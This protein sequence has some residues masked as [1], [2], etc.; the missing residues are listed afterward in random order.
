M[1][2]SIIRAKQRARDVLVAR[3]GAD[4]GVIDERR[5]VDGCLEIVGG[6]RQFTAGLDGVLKCAAVDRD[7]RAGLRGDG[8]HVPGDGAGNQLADD[9]AFGRYKGQAPIVVVEY[10][11]H[12]IGVRLGGVVGARDKGF[13]WSPVDASEVDRPAPGKQRRQQQDFAH[14]EQPPS[15]FLPSLLNIG[16]ARQFSTTERTGFPQVVA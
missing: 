1:T 12:E 4:G 8:C 9:G 2:G 10:P 11:L 16:F 14:S 7:L 5:E 3:E 6:E 13:E 15:F